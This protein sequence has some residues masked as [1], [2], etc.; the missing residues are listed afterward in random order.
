MG[1]K[2]RCCFGTCLRKMAG[3]NMVLLNYKRKNIFH[4]RFCGF[5]HLRLWLE[6]LRQ[7]GE[8]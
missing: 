8:K 7:L 2:Y 3:E 1:N 5:E 6:E 4:Q